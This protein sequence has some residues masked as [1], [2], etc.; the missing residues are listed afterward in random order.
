MEYPE[1]LEFKGVFKEIAELVGVCEAIKLFE[2]KGGKEVYISRPSKLHDDHWLVKLLGKENAAIFAER[3]GG[4]KVRFPF[5]PF[6]GQQSARTLAIHKALKEGFKVREI[7]RMLGITERCVFMHKR[8]VRESDSQQQKQ[9]IRPEHVDILD[10]IHRRANEISA[11]PE[12]LLAVLRQLISRVPSQSMDNFLTQLRTNE[13]SKQAQLQNIESIG[14]IDEVKQHAGKV[15][16]TM[17]ELIAVYQKL[18]RQVSPQE[19]ELRLRKLRQNRTNH[20]Y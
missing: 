6:H 19:I 15:R 1:S 8:I 12:E 5:G 4:G 9:K 10:E 18:L 2:V 3:F 20:Q 7:A 13:S 14:I 16:C 17:K 11:S